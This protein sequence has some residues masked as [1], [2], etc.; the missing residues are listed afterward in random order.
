MSKLLGPV[1]FK[2]QGNHFA[3]LPTSVFAENPEPYKSIS[4]KP[5]SLNRSKNP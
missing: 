2:A 5:K 3:I 4:P 1:T